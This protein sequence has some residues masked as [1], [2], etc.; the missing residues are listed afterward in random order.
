MNS[1]SVFWVLA[2]DIQ[3]PIDEDKRLV[4]R[5][6]V[7]LL[8]WGFEYRSR[9]YVDGE[10]SFAIR[11]AFIPCK[12]GLSIVKS[13]VY[14]SFSSINGLFKIRLVESFCIGKS[15]SPVDFGMT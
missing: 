4:Q 1:A 15:H 12:A 9:A 3:R 2:F 11:F 13:L 8:R 10:T 5:G 7:D 6:T 14:F